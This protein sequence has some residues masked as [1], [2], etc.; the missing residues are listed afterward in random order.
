MEAVEDLF[1]SRKELARRLGFCVMTVYR[2]TRQGR[3]PQPVRLA[4]K[5]IRYRW[6]DVIQMLNQTKLPAAMGQGV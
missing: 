4:P 5:T 6:A 1:L 2:M 3:L